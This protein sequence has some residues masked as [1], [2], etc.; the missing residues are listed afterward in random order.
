[1]VFIRLCSDLPSCD[2]HIQYPTL[3]TNCESLLSEGTTKRD[4]HIPSYN[5][6]QSS[7]EVSARSVCNNVF[8]KI[9]CQSLGEF[10]TTNSI[11]YESNDDMGHSALPD[12]C[13]TNHVQ[14]PAS[15][16]GSHDSSLLSSL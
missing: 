9:A 2:E 5:C 15:H 8:Q 1:M 4:E 10:Y 13:A 6:I 11:I 16:D 3:V 14:S 12:T 7:A